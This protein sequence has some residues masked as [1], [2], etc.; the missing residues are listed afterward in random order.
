[1]LETQ[2]RICLQALGTLNYHARFD[3]DGGIKMSGELRSEVKVTGPTVEVILSELRRHSFGVI[4]TV[5]GGGRSHSTGVM[6]AMVARGHGLTLYVMSD[7][8]A[9]KVKNIASNPNISFVVPLQRRFIT[10]APPGCIQF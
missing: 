8:R 4:S 1:M 2:E 10:F 6:Y 9:K 5:T 7:T 3:A